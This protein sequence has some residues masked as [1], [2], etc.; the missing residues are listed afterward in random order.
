MLKRCFLFTWNIQYISKTRLADTIK[1]LMIDSE[2]GDILVRIHTAIHAAEEAVDLASFIKEIVPKA[3]IIGTSTSAVIYEGRLYPDQC[4]VSVSLMSEAKLKTLRKD[5]P[6]AAPEQSMS[7]VD[8]CNEVKEALVSSDKGLMFTFFTTGYKDIKRFVDA[9]NDIMPGI[10][11]IGGVATALDIAGDDSDKKGF[12]FDE[13]GWSENGMIA[14]SISGGV[15]DCVSSLVSGVQLVGDEL[16]ITDAKDNMILSI[17]G[18]PASEKFREGVGDEI[19]DRPDLAYH[20]PFVY[21]GHKNVP[22]MFGCSD[23]GLQTNHNMDTGEKIIRGFIYDRKIVADNRRAFNKFETFDK[24]E[25]VIG[26]SC[27]DRSRNFPNSVMWELSIYENSNMSGCLTEGEIGCIDGMNVFC[28]SAFVISAAGESEAIQQFNPYVFS[29]TQALE[30][31]NSVLIGYLMDIENVHSFDKDIKSNLMDFIRNCELKLIYSEDGGMLNEAALNMDIKIKGYDR[32]C[33][34]DVLD[35]SSMQMVFSEQMI[36]ATYKNFISR[37]SAFVSGKD[38][39]LYLLDK[40]NIAIAAPSFMIS[41]HSFVDDMKQLQK[42]LF[43]T[44]EQYISI[45]PVFCVINGCTVDNLSSIYNSSRLEMARK[46]VQFFVCDGSVE[47]FDEDSIREKY[48]MV[49]VI[50]YALSHDKVIPY[51]MG[52]YDNKNKEIHHYEALMRLEDENGNVYYPGSFLGA[53]R[54]FGLLY[55]ELQRTMVRKVFDRF[56]DSDDKCVSINMGVRDIQNEEMTEYIYGFLSTAR[57]PGNFIFEILENEDVDNYDTLII[58]VD[59]VH[60]LG[61]H[62][63]I[64]DFG[65]GYSNLQHIASIHSDY[66]KIDGSIVRNC[67]EDPESENLVA[68]VSDWKRLSIRD[69]KIVAEYVEN[70]DIQN[71]LE[72]Y[73]IDFSQ[74]YYFSVPSPELGDLP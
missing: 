41:L 52:I 19:E 71:K 1:Q 43:E 39:R 60:K 31:D 10:Q 64:D 53:A 27:R 17:D 44:S 46:N 42:I 2:K 51:Y 33:L 40:W 32:V 66:I 26:Y 59:T 48:H 57:H 38:Y 58:F 61:G 22:F 18:V 69:I 23:D 67:Y 37:C 74:G 24:A 36:E 72:K 49:N 70:K 34:I 9:G 62:I 55:D 16:E 8:L 56:K 45:V 13:N 35:I 14:A 4:L 29:N 68:L 3:K 20:F 73:D 15:F 50:N 12:V 25:T 65:S 21:T 11:M 30:S 6:L 47:E 28:N 7:A 5:L 54:S 63:S